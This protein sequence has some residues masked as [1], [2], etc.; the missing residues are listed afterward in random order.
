MQFNDL[1]KQWESIRETVIEKI[2]SLGYNG[3]YI[4]GPAVSEFESQFSSHYGTKYSIGVSNGTDGLKLALQVL[5]LSNEDLVIIPSNTFIADYLAVKHLPLVKPRV[6]LIDHDE[7]F[8]LDIKHLE[9]FLKERRDDF[10]KVVVIPVH[11]YGHSCDMDVIVNLSKIYNFKIIEDCSQ[12]HET[13]Y[14]GSYLG[15]YGEMAVYSLYP[16][17]NLGACGDGGI[18]T[19]NDKFLC[20]RLKSIRNY[21]S[22]VKYHYDEIGYNNRLDSIQAIILSEKLKHL[23]RWTEIKRQI[24]QRYHAEIVNP[25]VTLP[26]ISEDCSVHSYHIFCLQVED[27][28]KFESHMNSAGIPT[29]IHYPIPIH[30]TS[31]F[32]TLDIVHSIS[33]T[34]ETCE[35]IV[36]IPIHPFLTEGEV[37]LIISSVNSY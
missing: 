7:N 15:S 36:S 24:A 9:L 20:E 27:R 16:G 11:L 8:T 22:K 4:N 19:T 12:S 18:I 5:D 35:K 31:I 10:N 21:G 37:D 13:K 26:V 29:I 2:D 6:A 34:D 14:K 25:K 33:R 17:K 28:K 23:E 30:Q 1:G 3:S 32:D